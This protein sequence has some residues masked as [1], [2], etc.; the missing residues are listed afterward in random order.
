MT[1]SKLEFYK[2]FFVNGFLIVCISQLVTGQSNYASHANNIEY[3][4]EGLPE[5]VT[6]DGKVTKLDDLSPIIFLNRTKAALNCAAGSMQIDLK[7]SEKFF[8]IAYA[9]FDRNSACQVLGKGDLNYRLELPLK[10]CGTKQEPQRV[11][12]NNIVV[13]FHPGLEMDG[14]EIITIV[15]RYPPPIP[16]IPPAL[17][18][19]FNAVFT[20]AVV[21]PPLKGI[22]ILFIIC[23]IMFLTLLLLGLGVSYYCLRRRPVVVRRLPMSM[24]SGS[25][26]TK[27]SGSSLGNISQ[28]EG[29]KIPRAQA[30]LAAVHSSS[31]SEGILIP[32]D[33]PSESHSEVEEI[34]AR[35][36]SDGSFQ[37]RAF[38]QDNSSIYSEHYGHTQE[39]QEANAITSIIP[40]LPIAAQEN[41][42]PK[43]DIQMRVKKSPPPPPSPL[44]SDSES[45]TTPRH[46]RNNLSVIMETHEDRESVLTMSSLPREASYSHFTYVPDLHTAPESEIQP[47][48][49]S[50]YTRTHDV[51][52]PRPDSTW[53]EDFTDA[54]PVSE[55]RSVFSQGTEMTDTH[56]V[57]EIIESTHLYE[58]RQMPEPPIVVR[59]PEVSSHIVDDIYLRTITEKKTIEDI[60]SHRRRITEYK[61]RSQPTP[62][63]DVTIRNYGNGDENNQPQWENFSDISSVSNMTL[64]PK[65]ERSSMTLPPLQQIEEKG[66]QLVSP[67][68]VGNMKPIE[69]PPEDKSV[70][71]WDVLIRVLEEPEPE[72]MEI[73]IDNASSIQSSVPPSRTLPSTVMSYDDRYKW[74]EIITQKSSLRTMLTEAVVKEDFERIRHDTRY[75]Q[76]FEPQTWD[77]I[78]R[79]LAPPAN[80]DVEIRLSKPKNSKEPW[81]TRSRRSSLPTLYEYD[82]DG[83][84][85]V[86]TIRNDTTIQS[87]NGSSSYH[88][89]QR[90]RRTSRSSYHTDNVD[91]RSMSEVIVDFG[92]FDNMSEVSS[93]YPQRS[94]YEDDASDRRS[95]HRS[96]SH[97][98]LARSGSEFMEHWVVPEDS[99][100]TSSPEPTPVVRRAKKAPPPPPP[101]PGKAGATASTSRKEY[102][103]SKIFK[104][105]EELSKD[106]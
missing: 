103:E 93:F 27:L 101:R 62:K 41:V 31:G 47:P 58:A 17:P 6:L 81:D 64:T 26:I 53:S 87:Q 29:L 28:F 43:F 97:P 89:P 96:I 50:V 105:H 8:G 48:I 7:F 55:T 38:V 14:D 69:I 16:S 32:S 23:A 1:Y 2:K 36:L 102:T 10:G 84:S 35:S 15:C 90:S 80:D 86:R 54:P 33:Y 74:K 5:E 94:Y 12:T 9:D 65:M 49:F 59:K 61:A 70:P 21:E 52:E 63:F 3:Q 30:P 100:Q 45:V 24:G 39:F 92:R 44:T 56:S 104:S 95:V 57:G 78:I 98:S 72:N 106:W 19:K 71:N 77:V 40:C 37:N 13:R 51:I 82:S 85:S 34:D 4:G 68:L 18:A 25:E 83:G 46:D 79:I 75:S 22:Q 11:F 76:I 66:E 60:E 99:D 88:I 42:S 73:E 67:H 20:G 91:F